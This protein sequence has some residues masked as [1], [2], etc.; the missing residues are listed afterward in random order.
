MGSETVVIS[1]ETNNCKAVGETSV[2]V[3]SKVI[4]IDRSE[5]TIE[6]ELHT[7]ARNAAY[8]RNAN[9]IRPLGEVKDGRRTYVFYRCPN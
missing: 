9:T 4:G 6:E 5:D 1:Y 8:E 7:L 2:K 3:L